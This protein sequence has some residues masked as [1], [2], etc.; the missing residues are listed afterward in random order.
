MDYWTLTSLSLWCLN[1]YLLTLQNIEVDTKGLGY[2]TEPDAV[3]IVKAGLVDNFL[4][5]IPI[6][7]QS[8]STVNTKEQVFLFHTKQPMKTT[9]YK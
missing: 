9:L 1:S 5:N 7:L 2:R 3:A 8:T 4:F 6:P